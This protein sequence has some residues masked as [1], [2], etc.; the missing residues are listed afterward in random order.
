MP[1]TIYFESDDIAPNGVTGNGSDG[2]K[3][4]GEVWI[5]RVVGFA[6]DFIK[7]FDART[8]CQDWARA[9]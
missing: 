1:G 8:Q 7:E 3:E 2:T 5:K 6:V 4:V 9:R